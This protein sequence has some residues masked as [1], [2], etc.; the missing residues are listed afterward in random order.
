[1]PEHFANVDEY[2]GSFPQD[3][4]EILQ[5]VRHAI[6]AAVPDGVEKI[7]YDIAA[8]MVDATHAIHFAGWKKHVGLYPVP[9]FEGELEEAIGPYRAAKDSAN[10]L[11]AR[12]I[13]Y[14]LI[15]R[16]AR[17]IAARH[18]G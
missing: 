16:I 6:L 2:I 9:R 5:R 15:E 18:S 11:Y 7:R 8:V 3:V 13:P 10:F 17:A 12:P 1:M 4:Q 14:E